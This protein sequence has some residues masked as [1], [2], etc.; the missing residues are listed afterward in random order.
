M[1]FGPSA[2]S[3][4]LS[5]RA[6]LVGLLLIS[7]NHFWVVQLEL[8]RYSLVSYLVPYYTVIFILVVLASL[9]R[10]LARSAHD[11]SV[12]RPAGVAVNDEVA[13][14]VVVMGGIPPGYTAKTWDITTGKPRVAG[15]AGAQS[16]EDWQATL[17]K[18]MRHGRHWRPPG[19]H[20]T[21]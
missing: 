12:A 13:P 11:A 6:I 21:A 10:L 3:N 14:N 2:P 7:I 16:L 8:V 1:A 4:V 19:V 18:M 20:S 17:K 5:W 9:N 15:G